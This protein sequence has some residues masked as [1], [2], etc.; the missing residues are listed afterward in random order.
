[1]VS[2]H[3]RNIPMKQIA[4]RLYIVPIVISLAAC[5]PAA[6][7]EAEAPAPAPAPVAAESEGP[8]RSIVNV[9]GDLY[10]A[11]NNNH[12]T[13]FLVT[14]EGIIMS[15]PINREFS[16]WLKGE[17]EARFN[18]SVRYVLYSHHH[19]DH[20]SG[21]G[22]F[23]D[24]AEFVGHENMIQA[25]AAPGDMAL[26]AGV[27]DQDANGNGEIEPAE[28]TG[29]M[30]NN[31][32]LFDFNEDGMLSGGEIAR[33]ALNDVHPPTQT[34]TD[35]LTVELGGKS[36]EMIHPGQAHSADMSVVHFPE[37]SAVF[38]VDWISLGRLPFRTLNGYD[39]EVWTGQ[40]RDVEAI[41][42]EYALPAHGVAGSTAD[43]AEHR[44]Y[45]EEVH[46]AV[47]EGIAAGASLEELQA[48]V[49]MD[50]Y[51]DWLNFEWRSDNVLGMYN[52]LTQ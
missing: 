9:T 47:A 29:N 23:A 40:M 10:F 35:R 45:L 33:G 21:G 3:M 37:E 16:T 28:A 49:T 6:E 38:F 24:T 44:Q 7:P 30:A 46:D 51:S 12:H 13:V 50:G 2:N 42:A 22:V 20:A 4:L 26:P 8:T 1:M 5:A 25:L 18:Q 41:G 32:A 43:I 17:L 52:S 48:S 27:A 19:W 15:D 39:H 34:Y 31:F 14:D 11:Q 36:V